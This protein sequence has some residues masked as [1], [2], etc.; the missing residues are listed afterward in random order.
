M[1]G[2]VARATISIDN[3]AC[4]KAVSSVKIKL[5]RMIRTIGFHNSLFGVMA[6]NIEN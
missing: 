5:M 4:K 6:G 3:T 2:E 1:T